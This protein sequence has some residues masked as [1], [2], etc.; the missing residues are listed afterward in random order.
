MQFVSQ[1][2][3]IDWSALGQLMRQDPAGRGIANFRSGG[4]LLGADHLEPAARSLAAARA[5][6]IITGFGVHDGEQYVAETDG[7]PGAI[8]L[9]DVLFHSGMKIALISDFVGMPALRT[10]RDLLGLKEV[11]LLEFPFESE[12]GSSTARQSN[13][14]PF[15]ER[16]N[17]WV[18][19]FLSSELG[20]CLTHLVAIERVGPSH[21]LESLLAQTRIGDP[22]YGDFERDVPPEHRNVCHNMRGA[23]INSST[24]KT[25]R[26]FEIVRQRKLPIKTIGIGDGGNEIGMGQFPWEVLRAAIAQGPAGRVA[27]RIPTDLTLLAGVSNWG[28]YALASAIDRLNGRER[29]LQTWSA[30]REHQ[31]L[32]ALVAKAHC[33]DG[34]TRRH[35]ATV[36]GL[37]SETLRNFWSSLLQIIR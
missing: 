32:Q 33:V 17:A 22:P 35:E 18:E 14:A 19:E 21:T 15:N 31:L 5:V 4:Q 13:D 36:D 26:L 10:S 11:S 28:G 1:T 29:F 25:H 30:E 23:P 3:P 37:A 16:S 27:C 7:P 8:A 6:A 2:P 12:D 9:A 34:L 20:C 24:A